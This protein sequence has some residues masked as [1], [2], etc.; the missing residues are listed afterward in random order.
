VAW[1]RPKLTLTQILAWADQH[2]SRLGSWPHAYAGRVFGKLNDNWRSIDN[3]LRLGLRG[4]PGGS[5]LARLLDEKRGVP[6]KQNLPRL[7]HANILRWAVALHQG[8]G[9][10]PRVKSCPVAEAPCE[11][12]KDIDMALRMGL[13]G[14]PG[15]DTLASCFPGSWANGTARPCRS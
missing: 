4:L 10:W 8:T 9:R 12:W 13:R 3:A 6:N 2:H 14:L 15:G 1:N 7:T 5:S 11:D